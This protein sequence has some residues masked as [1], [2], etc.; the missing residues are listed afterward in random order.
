MEREDD[1]LYCEFFFRECSDIPARGAH[2]VCA[3]SGGDD[4]CARCGWCSPEGEPWKPG[5]YTQ[6][7]DHVPG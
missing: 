7:I 3:D 2:P 4:G 6:K 1:G 5:T